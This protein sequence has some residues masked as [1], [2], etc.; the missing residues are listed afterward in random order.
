MGEAANQIEQHIRQERQDLEQNF[1]Q[2]GDKVKDAFD[3]KSQFHQHSG[4]L[5]GAAFVGGALLAVLVP[6]SRPNGHD[7]D[8]SVASR[9]QSFLEND[10][11]YASRDSRPGSEYPPEPSPS[12]AY[13]GY[14]SKTRSA[15]NETWDTLKAAAI[16]LASTRLSEY[17]DDLVPGFTDHYKRASTGDLRT[18]FFSSSSTPH[19]HSADTG[20]NG[21]TDHESHS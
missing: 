6:K 4:A 5:L 13:S 19:Q 2:L 7:D 10:N 1:N 16:G 18:P 9:A 14:T 3:W 21:A 20:A 12:R 15:S 8:R 11:P 17:L